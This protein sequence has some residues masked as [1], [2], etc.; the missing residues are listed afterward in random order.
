MKKTRKKSISYSEKVN[1]K[2]M[3]L[4]KDSGF[5]MLTGF[6]SDYIHYFFDGYNSMKYLKPNTLIKKIGSNSANGFVYELC[7]ERNMYNSY[8]VFKTTQP[9]KLDGFIPDNMAY[10]YMVGQF[11]NNFLKMYPCFIETYGLFHFKTMQDKPFL[12]NSETITSD[13]F[14]SKIV[15][16]DIEK[17]NVNLKFACKYYNKIGVL[18]QHLKNVY[19]LYA[20][21][22]S[23]SFIVDELIQFLYQIYLP[24]FMMRDIFTHRDLHSENAMAC[25]LGDGYYVTMHYHLKNKTISFHTSYISKILDYGRCY[26]ND[27]V[28]KIS[29]LDIYNKVWHS[30]TEDECTVKHTFRGLLNKNVSQDLLLISSCKIIIERLYDNPHVVQ[31]YPLLSKLSYIREALPIKQM[32]YPNTINNLADIYKGLENL[33]ETQEFKETN[34]SVFSVEKK[35]GDLHIYPES[36]KEI[37]FIPV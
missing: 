31:I 2:L 20:L 27:K 22:N 1:K 4:C 17:Y 13:V 7:F 14:K 21:F 34:Q 11:V 18:I 12:I 15:H 26:F 16:I 23:E 33:I 6:K 32:G 10:E 25:F 8:A 28:A 24:L 9:N 3:T 35:L 29:T 30:L 37:K 36:Q 19:S 5:C